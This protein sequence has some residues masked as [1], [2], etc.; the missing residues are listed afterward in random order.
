[1]EGSLPPLEAGLEVDAC[2]HAVLPENRSEEG[3]SSTGSRVHVSGAAR[4]G[5][6]YDAYCNESSGA[7]QRLRLLD[8]WF[9]GMSTAQRRGVSNTHRNEFSGGS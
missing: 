2:N 9:W 8:L 1:M 4:R 7:R 3:A 6:H 5:I